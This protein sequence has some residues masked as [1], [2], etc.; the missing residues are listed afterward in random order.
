MKSINGLSPK[1]EP[2]FSKNPDALIFIL[3]G[4]KH[5][6]PEIEY[7]KLELIRENLNLN[8]IGVEGWAGREADRMRGRQILNGEIELITSLLSNKNYVITG[9]ENPNLQIQVFEVGVIRTYKVFLF[10]ELV[11]L[12]NLPSVGV[13]PSEIKQI[14]DFIIDSVCAGM[15]GTGDEKIKMSGVY[16]EIVPQIRNFISR[17]PGLKSRDKDV[18]GYLKFYGDAML[19]IVI[20]LRGLHPDLVFSKRTV[21]DS[22]WALK[23]KYPKIYSYDYDSSNPDE[24]KT[25]PELKEAM[26]TSR[27]KAAAEI[28]LSSMLKA[29]QKTGIIV[30]GTLH[31]EGLI[32]ELIKQ[33]NN[34]VNIFII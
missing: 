15:N 25:I 30:F 21:E 6:S 2:V 1:A 8:F 26:V 11:L 17:F 4:D 10:F 23:N 16:D 32:E 27:N 3:I 5:G 12:K 31:I 22:L 29:K 19:N 33:A 18:F 28:M 13:P 14:M 7:G 34:N 24:T 20:E 9:L